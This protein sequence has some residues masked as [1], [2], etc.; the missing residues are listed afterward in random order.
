VFLLLYRTRL[1]FASLL[2]VV[3]AAGILAHRHTVT[4]SSP[5]HITRLLDARDQNVI[6]RGRIVSDTGYRADEREPAATE[7]LRFEL[8]LEALGQTGQWQR[9]DGRI[10]VFVSETREPQALRYGDAIECSAILRVPPT[11]RNT[12]T[13]DWRAWLARHNIQFTA[14]IRKSDLCEVRAR[15]G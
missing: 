5:V 9:V 10:L 11:T 6:L 2:V 12:G 8:E 7:R 14:T 13:F 15:P 1:S 3:F 4:I